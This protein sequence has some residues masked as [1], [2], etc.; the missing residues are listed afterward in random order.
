M[1]NK[2][3]L[4]TFLTSFVLVFFVFNVSFVFASNV[5]D[6]FNT[7]A[8]KGFGG[9]NVTVDSSQQAVDAMLSQFGVVTSL[10]GAIG[11]FI[12]A[13]LAFLGVIFLILI[14]YGG[15]SWMTARGNEQEVTKAQGLIQQAVIGLIIV[16]MAYAVTAFLGSTLAPQA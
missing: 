8:V 4:T 9:D 1:N 14:I 7:T 5:I 13:G 15:F 10:P 12:G 2:G 6:K 11:K 16:L 3:K